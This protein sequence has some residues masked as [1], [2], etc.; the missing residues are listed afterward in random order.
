[1]RLCSRAK[2]VAA[3][4]E[5]MP[6]LRKMFCRCRATVC[7]LITEVEEI[8]WVCLPCGDEAEHLHLSGRLP[9]LDPDAS[10]LIGGVH[11]SEDRQR[12]VELGQGACGIVLCVRYSA[13]SVSRAGPEKGRLER[14]RDLEQFIR[15]PMTSSL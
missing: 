9:D 14:F 8:S 3:V 10:G 15:C 4:R 13:L 2:A 6:S 5:G 11:P 1:M 12:P 7:S